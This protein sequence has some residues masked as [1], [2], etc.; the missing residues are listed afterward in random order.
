M[1][2]RYTPDRSRRLP[3]Q[4]LSDPEALHGVISRGIEALLDEMRHGRSERLLAYLA[5]SARFHHYSLYNQFLIY[6]QCPYATRVAGYRT[7]QELGYQVA[8]G[9]TGIRIL[10][11]HTY[12]CR[13]TEAEPN[14]GTEEK[15]RTEP[16]LY[17]VSVA[18]FDAS[19]L[20]DVEERPLPEFF[21]P[22]A[23][24]Q[25]E[26]CV[27][28]ER[29]IG[30]EGIALRESRYIERAQGYSAGG[31]IT[32]KAG[33]DSR[34]RFLV[35]AHEFAH[36]L[37]H[38]GKGAEQR[39]RV[40]ECH[41]EAVSYVVAAHFGIDNPFAADYLQNW[42]NTPADLLAELE[43]VRHTAARIIDT[44]GRAVTVEYANA[45]EQHMPLLGDTTVA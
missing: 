16:A 40:Q 38:W 3:A 17:F 5:F 8:K 1:T 43:V 33:L 35:L 30:E 12:R 2:R 37:L 22:L 13:E 29:A 23:D 9:A 45:V 14:G 31:E 36:E 42:G 11:P 10:A 15:E 32:I 26:L 7:W 6:S 25:Q 24:D 20:V 34:R 27:R 21:T 19:Q 4:G 41:A 28:L 39:R 44:I 18:V